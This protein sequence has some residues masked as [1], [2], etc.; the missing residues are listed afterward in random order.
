MSQ[1]CSGGTASAGLRSARAAQRYSISHTHQ[2]HATIVLRRAS[3]TSFESKRLSLRASAGGTE[4]TAAEFGAPD[5]RWHALEN[6]SCAL[7]AISSDHGASANITTSIRLSRSANDRLQHLRSALRRS[8]GLCNGPNVATWGRPGGAGRGGLGQRYRGSYPKSQS[9]DTRFT[10]YP[11][12]SHD[13]P[14]GRCSR[15]ILASAGALRPAPV[16]R[17]ALQ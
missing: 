9:P 14:Y 17:N 4:V 5:T 3:M 12:C 1:P 6:A 11:R 7:P 15:A 13:A 10:Q 2:S 8:V 16:V